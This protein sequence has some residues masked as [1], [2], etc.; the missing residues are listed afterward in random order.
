MALRRALA[1]LVLC[2]GCHYGPP[3]DEHGYQVGVRTGTSA[4]DYLSNGERGSLM[5]T[6]VNWA[7]SVKGT[8]LDHL[9]HDPRDV[10][11]EVQNKMPR[12]VHLTNWLIV[13]ETDRVRGALET[14]D[15]ARDNFVASYRLPERRGGK[16]AYTNEYLVIARSRDG[17][18]PEADYVIEDL[19]IPTTNFRIT[20]RDIDMRLIDSA[21]SLGERVFAGGY[22][23][24]SV[25]SMERV[26]LIFAND[27]QREASFHA[28]SLNP[29]STTALHELLRSKVAPSHRAFTFATPG[30]PNSPDYS[31]NTSSG[32]FE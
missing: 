22:D 29:F 20:L 14:E 21:G 2:L 9:V 32:S 19:E 24:V 8:D 1:A 10:F 17:A 3:D 15:R 25:R 27:G 23:L 18:F 26:Q 11:I 6:E 16:P 30:M 7:G 31:G 13:I 4:D 5:I 28:Y 12:P